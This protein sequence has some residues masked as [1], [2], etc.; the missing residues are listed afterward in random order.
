MNTDRL[1]MITLGVSLA[2]HAAVL[3]AELIMPGWGQWSQAIKPLKLIYEPETIQE[4]PQLTRALGHVREGLKEVSGPSTAMPSSNMLASGYH[5]QAMEVDVSNLVAHINVGNVLGG[6]GS[7]PGSSDHGTWETAIDLTNLAAA[8]QGD[9]VLYTYFGAIREQIQHT[10][11]THAW[12]PEEAINPGTVY[13]GFV[14]SRPGAIESVGVVSERSADSSILQQ[15]ALHIV[16]AAGPFLPF[17]PSFQESSKAI[18]VPI[19]FSVGPE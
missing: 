13:V 18:V 6:S 11:N 4:Q 17:P 19:E 14:I 15:A 1:F 7:L 2:G 3:G 10:A 16:Q 5:P 12:L 8:A 9:P